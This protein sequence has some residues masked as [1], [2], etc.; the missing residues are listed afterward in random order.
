MGLDEMEVCCGP[1]YIK[2]GLMV[3]L[4]ARSPLGTRGSD[5]PLYMVLLVFELVKFIKETRGF[6]MCRN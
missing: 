3:R 1:Q 6:Q 2:E 4:V 5:L